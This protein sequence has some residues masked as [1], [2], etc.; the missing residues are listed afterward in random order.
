MKQR[1]P[2]THPLFA[3]HPSDV[4]VGRGGGLQDCDDI[5]SSLPLL[6]VMEAL[7]PPGSA[8]PFHIHRHETVI[9]YVLAG[10]IRFQC[11]EAT[12]NDGP[13]GFIYL[14][15]G[16]PHR[17]KVGSD[18]ARMLCVVTPAGLED[19]YERVGVTASRRELPILP[20]NV[21]GWIE[22]SRAH[23]IEIVGPPLL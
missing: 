13:G 6:T 23:G 9:N 4:R 5:E 22:L 12:F 17:F 14:P 18:S 1:G 7:M 2:L 19:L 3:E 15:K 11:G 21:A 20:P 10:E 8:P 16:V